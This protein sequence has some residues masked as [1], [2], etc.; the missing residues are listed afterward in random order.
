MLNK[1]HKKAFTLIELLIVIAIIG[2]LASVV[3]VSL[4]SAKNK[5]RDTKRMAE[6]KSIQA[7]LEVYYMAMGQY[8]VSDFDG[9]GGWD[10][11]NQSFPF[12]SN[13]ATFSSQ[14]L[15]VDSIATGN[16]SGYRYYRYNAGSYGCDVARGAYYVLG[17]VDLETMSRPA[18]GS[19]GW[20]CPSRNWQNEFDWVVGKFEK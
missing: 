2:I 16:C 15:P 1:K 11:G 17:I 9:C 19:P 7:A 3:L 6:I 14:V 13:L 8:P 5:T 18:P 10:V 20:S 12:I 4:V